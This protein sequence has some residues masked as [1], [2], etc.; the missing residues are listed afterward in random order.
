MNFTEL[1]NKYPELNETW[2]ALSNWFSKNKFKQFAEMDLLC[3][4][5]VPAKDLGTAL[6]LMCNEK[7]L[8]TAY[9]VKYDGYLLE[10]SYSCKEEIP[11]KLVDRN[12]VGFIKRSEC[13]IVAG[14]SWELPCGKQ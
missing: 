10:N 4:I 1:K 3:K 9:R 14:F 7:M 8:Q 6:E 5:K 2:D 11:K 12:G 13:E